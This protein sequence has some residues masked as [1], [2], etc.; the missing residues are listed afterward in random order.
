MMM[1]IDRLTQDDRVMLWPDEIWPQDIIALAFLDGAPLLDESRGFRIDAIRK[2]I[3]ARLHLVP[4][5][6]RVL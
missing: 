6:R 5:F 3:E 2:A 4:R 1:T